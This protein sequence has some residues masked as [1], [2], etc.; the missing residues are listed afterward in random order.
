M[1]TAS[2][3]GSPRESVGKKDATALRAAGN[4]P[5]VLYGGSE[6]KHFFVNENDLN[7]L[8]YSPDVYMID[9][10]LGGNKAS[11][12]I[13]DLQ[14]HPVTDKILHMDLL[15]L[16]DGKPVEVA[17]PVRTQG[18]S[19]GVRNGGRLS[20][21]Y[22]RLPLRALPADLPDSVEIDVTEV[23]IGDSV[24]VRDV[25]IPGCTILAADSAVIVDVK[26]TRAAMAAAAAAEADGDD[27]P[28]A[29]AA[30]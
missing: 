15:E 19:V 10:D 25:E 24:R 29:A 27:A 9:F 3:S 7:K 2:L 8:V 17:L 23:K 22:R 26:R 21:N 11:A 30:E 6:E 4:I 5:G 18:N 28:A 20:I 1:K 13:K 12:I 16:T 14:F